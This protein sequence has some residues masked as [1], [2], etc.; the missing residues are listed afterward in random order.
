MKPVKVDFT[1]QKPQF[2]EAKAPARPAPVDDG[3]PY[4]ELVTGGRFYYNRP[5]WDIG[6]IAHA[7]SL[8]CRFTGQ[9]RK[10]YSVGEH[11]ILV[12]RIMEHLGLGD[13]MEGLL[14]DAVESVLSDVARPAKQLLK[15]YKA[16]DKALDTSMRKTFALPEAMTEGCMKADVMA[17][18]MEAKELMPSKGEHWNDIFTPELRAETAR[19]SFQVVGWTPENTK[20]RF[21]QRMTDIRRRL[22]GLR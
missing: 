14:H 22:R 12:S 11:S 10:F 15:D 17:L 13:P 3:S 20:E 18:L 7:L 21:M 6:A 19:L 5:E 2:A 1:E 9:C 16:L 4:I 8:Q